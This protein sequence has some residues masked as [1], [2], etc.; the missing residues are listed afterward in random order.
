MLYNFFD[1]F[2]FIDCHEMPALFD[3]K[4]GFYIFIGIICSLYYF[5]KFN[6]HVLTNCLES[7]ISGKVVFGKLRALIGHYDQ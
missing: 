6:S 4:F 5:Q 7:F 2:C 3:Y 1:F